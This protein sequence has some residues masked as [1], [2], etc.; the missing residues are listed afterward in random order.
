[1]T[2]PDASE[3]NELETVADVGTFV[4]RQ[5]VTKPGR[6][7]KR[8]VRVDDDEDSGSDDIRVPEALARLGRRGLRFGQRKLYENVFETKVTG[9]AYIPPFGGYIVAAN[10]ASHL[11]MGLVKHS[12]GENGDL[13]VALAAKDYFFDD[14]V[15]KAYFENFTNLMPMERYGS[16]RESLR[17]AGD[18]IR[19]G[20]ILLIFP[21]GT[22]SVTGVMVDFK[23]SLGYLA[24]H[25]RCGILPMYLAGT[26]D[27][28][29][30]GSYMPKQREIASHVGP[31]ISYEQLVAMTE[32][33][34]RSESY[35]AIAEEVERVVRS[36]APPAYEWTL[37]E[38]GRTPLASYE[39]DAPSAE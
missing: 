27:A 35:R 37:G 14:P 20:E 18:V 15:R 19:E 22:R 5:G 6:S 4:A 30:K 33:M 26:H 39:A 2:L 25:N 28:L 13:L 29:P 3:I 12:L 36:M 24:L 38:A 7:S 23:P 10:H 31:F 21:E 32:G 1:V 8:S 9:K 11:D 34:S 17:M 16:L